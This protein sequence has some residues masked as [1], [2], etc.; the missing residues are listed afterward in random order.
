MSVIVSILTS[1][2]YPEPERPT[3]EASLRTRNVRVLYICL[4]RILI[5]GNLDRGVLKKKI[6][7][8]KKFGASKVVKKMKPLQK[9]EKEMKNLNEGGVENLKMVRL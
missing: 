8:G 2:V 3:H 4:S 5:H 6:E 1:T 7:R 9:N